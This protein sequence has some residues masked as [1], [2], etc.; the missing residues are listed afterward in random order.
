MGVL[1]GSSN[2]FR[3]ADLG[4]ALHSILND[5]GAPQLDSNTSAAVWFSDRHE[6]LVLQ[7]A[8]YLR[9]IWSAPVVAPVG[10]G[11]LGLAVPQTTL[12]TVQHNLQGLSRYLAETSY[13][14]GHQYQDQV[15]AAWEAEEASVAALRLLVDHTV[16]AISF[17]LLLADYKM[18]EILAR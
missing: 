17:V 16:E 8:R 2:D 18:P 10:Q 1:I 11:L 15:K 3:Q 6:G 7:L 12:Q 5:G 4:S 13:L 14:G 9:P